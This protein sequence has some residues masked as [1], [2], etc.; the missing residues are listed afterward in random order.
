MPVTNQTG[1]LFRSL[2]VFYVRNVDLL[3]IESRPD[4][5]APFQY[6]FYLDLEGSPRERRV[7]E[8]LDHLREF[9]KLY[10]LLGVYPMGKG[11]FYGAR[12]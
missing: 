7:A 10:R 5:E 6:M 8:A 9:S 4:P 1:I 12:K 2:G 11:R 3:K